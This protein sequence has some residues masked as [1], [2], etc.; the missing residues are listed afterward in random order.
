[1]QQVRAAAIS[2]TRRA[3]SPGS[4]GL[5]VGVARVN[6]DAGNLT[7]ACPEATVIMMVGEGGAEE[8]QVAV[9]RGV[10]L[11]GH[12]GRVGRA[13]DEH[14][15]R[16]RPSVGRAIRRLLAVEEKV[17]SVATAH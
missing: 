14:G 7:G 8:H 13:V 11:V 2:S 9:H 1:M 10:L 4:I 17:V 15:C 16:R 3:C 12:V 6:V 5:I